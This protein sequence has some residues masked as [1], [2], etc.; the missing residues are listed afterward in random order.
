MVDLIVAVFYQPFLDALVYSYWLLGKVMENPDMGVAVILFT[1]FIR[2]LL[3]PLSMAST[4]SE[5][6]RIKIGRDFED[7]EKK[8]ARSEPLKFTLEKRKLVSTNKNI[9]VF[10]ALNLGIQ[11]GIA[12]ILWFVFSH[13]LSGDGLHLLYSWMPEIEQPFNLMF[14]GTIDLTKSSV[15]L[16]LLSSALLFVVETLNISFSP[17]PPTNREHLVQVLLPVMT[18]VYLFTM[19]AGKK[20]FVITTLLFSIMF[21]FIREIHHTVVLAKAR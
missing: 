11:F 10:E 20:L 5:E 3:L 1:I 12:I 2:I 4:Q 21:I 8:Y 19:P 15:M 17:I 6:E 18:F 7:L 13:G 9:V 16:N 14:L